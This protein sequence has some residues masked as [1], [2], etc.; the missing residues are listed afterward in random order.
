MDGYKANKVLVK[1]NGQQSNCTITDTYRSS[2]EFSEY[3]KIPLMSPGLIQLRK[4]VLRGL[5]SGIK[6][7]F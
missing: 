5:I 2:G 3:R 4:R 6:N 7:V 1:R